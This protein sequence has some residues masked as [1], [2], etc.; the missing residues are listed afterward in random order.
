[1][2]YCTVSEVRNALNLDSTTPSDSVITEFI[3]RADQA[4]DD[5][6]YGDSRYFFEYIEPKGNTRFLELTHA[7]SEISEVLVDKVKYFEWKKDNLI[8]N[9]DVETEGS[10]DDEPEYWTA[11]AGSGDTLSWDDA[12]S[13]S[14]RQS[15]KIAKGASVDSYW[16]SDDVSVSQGKEYVAKGR[17]KVD[18]NTSGNTYLKLEFL[19]SDGNVTETET[20][21]AVTIEITQPSSASTISV[22]SDS[23]DDTTQTVSIVG[24]VNGLRTE[25][26]VELNGTSSVSTTNSFS[27]IESIRKSGTTSG[28]ITCTSNAGAVT[29]ATFTASQ[30]LK[31]DW[32]EVQVSGAVPYDAL[33]ARIKFFVSSSASSGSAYGDHFRLYARNWK[34]RYNQKIIE[35]FESSDLSGRI[36]DV[37]YKRISPPEI[38][39]QLS[40]DIASLYVLAY[41]TG[42]KTSGTNYDRLFPSTG[43]P[44]HVQNIINRVRENFNILLANMSNKRVM[45][46]E[47]KA[48]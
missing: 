21:D 23:S 35:L 11:S 46:S 22:S 2:S 15:L 40:I 18:S 7:F 38:T 3:N 31:E 20:S 4:I 10:T 16:V 25:E 19:D 42:G 33:S 29:N 48:V 12:Y 43:N 34:P 5:K 47:A 14:L 13:Y 27:Y 32:I 6:C 1:M 41:L 36:V 37:K 9:G 26:V 8:H 28:T 30:L 39:R 24:T 44:P 45:F 17:I